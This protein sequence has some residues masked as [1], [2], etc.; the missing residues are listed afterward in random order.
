MRKTI[1]LALASLALVGCGAQEDPDR[2]FLD[3]IRQKAPSWSQVSDDQVQN[4]MDRL[5]KRSDLPEPPSADVTDEDWGY[6]VG[7]VRGSERC[8]RV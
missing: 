7:L 2:P 6:V 4:Y 1:V 3:L 8:E 5:C